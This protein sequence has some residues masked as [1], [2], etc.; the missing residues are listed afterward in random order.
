MLFGNV[1]VQKVAPSFL[2]S[3]FCPSIM[4]PSPRDGLPPLLNRPGQ[5]SRG[6]GHHHFSFGPCSAETLARGGNMVFGKPL[7]LW[8]YYERPSRLTH[9]LSFMM[10][11]NTAPAADSTAIL[12]L[13][14]LKQAVATLQPKQWNKLC[15]KFAANNRMQ[16]G[17]SYWHIIHSLCS[18]PCVIW[19]RKGRWWQLW[20]STL[21]STALIFKATSSLNCHLFHQL[22]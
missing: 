7:L 1:A 11:K 10:G 15:C 4:P 19:K 2:V 18:F 6:R 22:S 5:E 17:R 9:D 14:R 20:W 13:L 21:V 12:K 16:N 8:K 3:T